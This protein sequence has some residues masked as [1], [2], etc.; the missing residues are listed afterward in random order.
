ML[1]PDFFSKRHSSLLP[2]DPQNA[3]SV[4]AQQKINLAYLKGLRIRDEAMARIAARHGGEFECQ[5]DWTAD[6]HTEWSTCKI[7]WA[8][9]VLY[10]MDLEF[11]RAGVTGNRLEEI[12]KLE[13]EGAQFSLELSG[14]E[15]LAVWSR[16]SCIVVP[17]ATTVVSADSKPTLTHEALIQKLM[18]SIDSGNG[19]FRTQAEFYNFLNIHCADYYRWKGKKTLRAPGH[20]KVIE[21]AISRLP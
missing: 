10:A 14:H 17:T 9:T 1:T 8:F 5:D 4:E 21:G 11:V 19:P 20:A 2:D 12:L 6:D 7:N 3:L 15:H 16:L 13:L 18:R